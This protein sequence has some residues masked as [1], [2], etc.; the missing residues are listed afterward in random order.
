M[1]IRAGLVFRRQVLLPIG[2]RRLLVASVA[3][4][5][6]L[7]ACAVDRVARGA[8]ELVGLDPVVPFLG[9]LGV[10]PGAIAARG[11]LFG[12]LRVRI[13]AQIARI[14]VAVNAVASHHLVGGGLQRLGEP[15]TAVPRANVSVTA[16]AI[17]GGHPPGF[18]GARQEV[19]TRDAGH[20][21]HPSV[22]DLPILMAT[23]ASFRI[24]RIG[25]RLAAMTLRAGKARRTLDVRSVPG[26]LGQ[27]SDLR[28]LLLMARSAPGPIGCAMRSRCF[29]TTGSR[30]P[31]LVNVL[32]ETR[33]VATGARRV[34]V[35]LVRQVRVPTGMARAAERRVFREV[36]L[37]PTR[38]RNRNRTAGK[39][40]CSQQLE[41]PRTTNQPPHE[42]ARRLVRSLVR[43]S[44]GQCANLRWSRVWSRWRDPPVEGGSA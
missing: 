23:L 3:A 11:L 18:G 35:S 2:R 12:V 1:A 19:V 16:T 21:L 27:W 36:V 40:N 13:V 10:T 22:V 26:G 9:H 5:L 34:R 17:P 24:R 6:Q 38:R 32:G 15:V 20:V 37:H 33:L 30:Q 39:R 31:P 7:T 4:P 43:F 44:S 28:T 29:R 42:T 14:E 25:V 41:P 8:V